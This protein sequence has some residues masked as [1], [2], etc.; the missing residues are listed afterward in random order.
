MAR[1]GRFRMALNKAAREV[2]QTEAKVRQTESDTLPPVQRLARLDTLL[3]PGRGAVKERARLAKPATKKAKPA[4]V[5]VVDEAEAVVVT[6]IL[7]R[8]A[9]RAEPTLSRTSGKLVLYWEGAGRTANVPLVSL[10]QL[11]RLS[12]QEEFPLANYATAFRAHLAQ[13]EKQ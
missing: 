2:R 4:E 3:G 10:S 12:Q 5:K 13:Q 1:R 7:V 6:E 8:S 9:N 11:R